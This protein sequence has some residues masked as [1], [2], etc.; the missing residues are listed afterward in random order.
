M[1]TLIPKYDQGSTGAVNRPINEKLA[2]TVSVLDFIP[3]GTNTSSTDCTAYIQAAINSIKATGGTVFFP[4]GEY[5]VATSLD[6]SNVN[7]DKSGISLI[8]QSAPTGSVNGSVI[9]FTSASGTRLVDARSALG[10][11]FEKIDFWQSNASYANTVFDFSH[12]TSGLDSVLVTFRDCAFVTTSLAT[13]IDFTDSIISVFENLH[14]K[15]GKYSIYANGSYFNAITLTGCSFNDLENAPIYLDGLTFG[16][17]IVIQQCTF[18][19]LADDSAAGFHSTQE[20]NGFIYTG[21]YHGDS[22]SNG[23]WFECAGNCNGTLIAGNT[24]SSGNT[25]VKI[26]GNAQ[27]TSVKNNTFSTMS[28]GID[29]S[30]ST[31][32]YGDYDS[33][34]WYIVTTPISGK[35]KIGTYQEGTGQAIKYAGSHIFD[36]TVAN[37]VGD[38]ISGTLW[39]VVN[40]GSS[41]NL[42]VKGTGSGNLIQGR[43]AS[44]QVFVT[45][46]SGNTYNANGVF[47]TIS[48]ERLKDSISDATPKLDDLL[49]VRVR[50]Y[51]LKQDGTKTKQIGVVAQELENVFPGLIDTNEDGYKAVKYSVFVPILIKAVQELSAKVIA[52]EAK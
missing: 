20:M 24:F 52:L 34:F 14:F 23:T 31:G 9:K 11:T 49:N 2:E 25:G 12:S 40:T 29:I 22:N 26:A 50:N 45:G 32:A 42:T 18:E 8:G 37:G 38:T 36:N 13:T 5:V 41:T 19:Q 4:I 17:S 3:S 43:D 39:A 33:N 10:L 51:V 44:N 7:A 15:G 6:L 1:A 30:T 21:N 16:N 47:G 35:P 48:D 46:I 28:V 27:G